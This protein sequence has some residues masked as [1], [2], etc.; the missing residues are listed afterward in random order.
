MHAA[1]GYRSC[2]AVPQLQSGTAVLL[3]TDHM[4]QHDIDGTVLLPLLA[5]GIASR[6]ADVVP[7]IQ[8]THAAS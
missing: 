8:E 5:M 2:R 4:L 1:A 7:H 3:S 6:I